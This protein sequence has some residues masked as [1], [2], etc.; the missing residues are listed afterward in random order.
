QPTPL[1][2]PPHHHCLS[3]TR[4]RAPPPVASTADT[5]N[6]AHHRPTV[7]A[8]TAATSTAFPAAAAAVA[9]CG[10]PFG[11]HRRGGAY[12]NL[13]LSPIFPCM[14]V[15]SPVLRNI[16]F[17]DLIDLIC[18]SNRGCPPP[19][20]HRGGGRTTTQPSQPHLVVSGLWW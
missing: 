5:T 20:H 2:P 12:T 9:G 4:H 6:T 16:Y 18:S 7:Y 15:T 13:D 17:S 14:V 10:W 19:N 11:H 8:T 1:P 3:V